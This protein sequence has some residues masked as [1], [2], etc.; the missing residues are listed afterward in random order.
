MH[1]YDHRVGK[2]VRRLDG[3]V[4]VHVHASDPRQKRPPGMVE[5]VGMLV[6]AQ[7]HGIDV[8]DG[9]GRERRG[10]SLCV[11]RVR[12]LVMAKRDRRLGR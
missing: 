12:R 3:I 11:R 5:V 10:R 1:R 8:T 4:D 7:E 6:V 9:L 2:C